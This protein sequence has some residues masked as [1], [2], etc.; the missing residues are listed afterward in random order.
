MMDRNK[1]IFQ[2]ECIKITTPS[3]D[4]SGSPRQLMTHRKNDKRFDKEQCF[5][6]SCLL[7]SVEVH[8]SGKTGLNSPGNNIVIGGD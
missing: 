3:A 8:Y 1:S 2:W 4:F 7:P 6:A 5:Q